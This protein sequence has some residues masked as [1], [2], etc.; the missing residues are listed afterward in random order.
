MALRFFLDHD[1]PVEIA[2]VLRREMHEVVELRE[3]LAVTSR[4]EEVFAY[5]KSSR[6]GCS[7]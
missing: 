5:A 6:M 2:R 3:V 1:V 7:W 4:D